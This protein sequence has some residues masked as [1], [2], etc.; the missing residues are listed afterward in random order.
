MLIIL[1]WLRPLNS[2]IVKGSARLDAM[3]SDRADVTDAIVE[4][5]APIAGKENEGN[6]FSKGMCDCLDPTRLESHHPSW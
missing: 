5:G 4:A 3:T 6:F 2:G 1:R